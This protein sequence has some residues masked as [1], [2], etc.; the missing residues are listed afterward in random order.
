MKS[1]GL[2]EDFVSQA[3]ALA[4]KN[5][6]AVDLM[7]LWSEE[8]SSR[9]RDELV[10]D[11]QE[12]LDDYL[13]APPEPV[14]RPKIEFTQLDH[15]VSQ[16]LEHKQRLRTLVDQ[17]GGVSSVARRAGIPQPSLSRMLASATMPRRTTLYKIAA[18]LDLS[19]PEIVGEWVR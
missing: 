17:H 9:H 3:M 5:E 1:Q 15:I 2:P 8:A 7:E 4:L 16:I 6:G 19:E 14:S 10:A 18:A 13:E 11:L 12:L